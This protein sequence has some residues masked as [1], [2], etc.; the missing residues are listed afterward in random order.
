V[1]LAVALGI[2]SG[3]GIVAYID[4][5]LRKMRVGSVVRRIAESTAAA[6][7]RQYHGEGGAGEAAE[8][9]MEHGPEATR[10]WAERMG[11]VRT[12][13]AVH[14]ARTVSP[15][16]L[17][18]VE[19]R[20]GEFVAE[21][22]LLATVWTSD[23]ADPA[24][25]RRAV[26]HAV[27][28]GRER[29]AATDPGFGIRQMVDIALRALS[30]GI[31]DPTTAVEV[32]HHLKVPLRGILASDAPARVF[33]GPDRQRVFMPEAPSRSDRVHSAFAEIRMAAAGQPAVLRALIEVSADLVSE[34]RDHDLGSRATAVL[35][36]GRLAVTAA[37][38]AGF[39]ERD[40]EWIMKAAVRLE[41]TD[42]DGAGG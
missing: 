35:E 11:W 2:A 42:E 28:L 37:R 21:G 29:S 9:R 38:E 30:P 34:L 10:V 23:G 1:T 31:N 40:L 32:L 15:G 18:R 6:V 22:D 16:T 27:F 7:R 24:R 25:S 41:S 17:V 4:H 3:I 19:V 5:S 36:E 13:D 8:T 33:P 14:L 12:I 20:V 26:H 39:P